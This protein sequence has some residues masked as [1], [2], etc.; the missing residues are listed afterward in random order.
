MSTTGDLLVRARTSAGLTQRELGERAGVAQSVVSAY[1]NGRRKPSV[2]TLEK[3]VTA[4]GHSLVLDLGPAPRVGTHPLRDLVT[5]HREEMLAVVAE[6]GGSNLRLF[7]SVARGE[8]GPDSDVD[9]L[10]DLP[11]D[12]GFFT[13]LGIRDRLAEVIGAPVDLVPESALRRSIRVEVLSDAVPV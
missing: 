11:P 1:E 10:V 5:L 7:G 12:T 9:L 3:L 8:E 4:A 2:E 13:L 6:R